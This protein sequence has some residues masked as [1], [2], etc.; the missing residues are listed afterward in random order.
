MQ[1]ARWESLTELAAAIQAAGAGLSL[2]QASKAV[3]AMEEDLI[4]S[5]SAGT[6]T[7]GSP[8]DHV[9]V[10]IPVLG[11]KVFVRLKVTK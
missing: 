4:V 2:P 11:T 9:T 3:Q 5:K 8:S 1:R 7:P 10:T 6:I